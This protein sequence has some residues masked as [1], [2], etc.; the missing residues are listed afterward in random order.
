MIDR[1]KFVRGAFATGMTV[2]RQSA[3]LTGFQY[4]ARIQRDSGNTSTAYLEMMQTLETSESIRAAAQTV[5]FSFYARAGA[6]YSAT[7]NSLSV[8]IVTGTGSDQSQESFTG[9]ANTLATTVTLTTSWQR[10][11]VSVAIPSGTTGIGVGFSYNPTGT[12]GAADYYDTTG[13]QLEVNQIAT[14]FEFKPYAQELRDCQRYYIQ[15]NSS[16]FVIGQNFGYANSYFNSPVFPI[17]MR[18]TP[19][20][21]VYVGGSIYTGTA[22]QMNVYPGGSIVSI[23]QEIVSN[24][25]FTVRVSGNS[26]Y[27][28]GILSY[29]ANAEL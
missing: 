14:T 7:N 17:V 2:S 23:Y 27:T 5:S 8:W 19:T 16:I 15:D 9:R 6:N 13:L 21:T 22:N 24:T 4:C 18:T 26:T 28:G 10:F 20:L 3:N 11:T 1:W 12:A 25:S 29:K